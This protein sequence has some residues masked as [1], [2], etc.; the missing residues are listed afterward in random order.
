M[1]TSR[2]IISS[3]L[4]VNLVTAIN[5]DEDHSD[6]DIALRE[7]LVQ[8]CISTFLDTGL[9]KLC[10]SKLRATD[11]TEHL[12][13]VLGLFYYL[14]SCYCEDLQSDENDT[15]LE[16]S[17]A[18]LLAQ[19][20]RTAVA[21]LSSRLTADKP[22]NDDTA[23]PGQRTA[24]DTGNLWMGLTHLV[25]A[26]SELTAKDESLLQAELASY[27]SDVVKLLELAQIHI[28][29]QKP[30]L[31]NAAQG[32]ATPKGIKRYCLGFIAHMAYKNRAVQDLV[33]E[34]SGL[35][36]ILAQ[37]HVD[38]ANPYLLEQATVCINFLLENNQANQD[39]V[40]TLKPV[41]V[42]KDN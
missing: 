37:S 28:P 25:H 31:S 42:Q 2:E 30:S 15:R 11:T 9:L 7:R 34:S 21:A 27:V 13:N 10:I 36:L 14:V 18:L 4:F 19:E 3:R 39:L 35:P 24:V 41:A 17:S 22:A 16:A 29:R 6:A 5:L 12:P 26:L 32:R 1:L 38:D 20:L 23:L 8:V 33:R 40:D